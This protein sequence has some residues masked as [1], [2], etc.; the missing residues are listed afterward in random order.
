MPESKEILLSKASHYALG[1]LIDH[2]GEL[3]RDRD[4]LNWLNNASDEQ[5]LECLRLR[6]EY[7]YDDWTLTDS[8]LQIMESQIAPPASEV[9]DSGH[10]A[11]PSSPPA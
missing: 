10:P 3:E 5:I 11:P 9:A 8:V 1:H 7:C 6:N 2:L 4:V